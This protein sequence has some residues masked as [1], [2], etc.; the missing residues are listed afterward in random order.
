MEKLNP[1][2]PLPSIK[3]VIKKESIAQLSVPTIKQQLIL[4]KSILRNN[5]DTSL[6]FDIP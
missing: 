5:M 2:P 6:S 4:Q 1:K 3:H